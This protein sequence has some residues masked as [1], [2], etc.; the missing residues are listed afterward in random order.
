VG[1]ELVQSDAGRAFI[2][3]VDAIPQLMAALKDTT[4]RYAYVSEGFA[5]RV[6]RPPHR[7]VG[8]TVHELFAHDLAASYAEQD[9]SVLRTGRPLRSHLELIVRADRSLGWYVT[10]KTTITHDGHPIGLAVLSVDLH[11]QLH[12]AHA[13]LAD[14]IA[15]IRAEV[16]RAWRVADLADVAGL[17]PVQ[18]E[19]QS[20]RTLGLSPRK[21]IQRLRI[22]HA[23][24]LIT[25]TPATIG[26]ISA[27]C[28]FYD[29]SSFTRQFRAVLGLTPG[30]YRI[31]G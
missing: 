26:E 6:G 3:L 13:G 27:I 20:R 23:V 5:H 19:R 22:E 21:L 1:V 31:S 7:I 16:G 30:A 8:R 11:S 2:D 29:Q 9:E 24:H 15:A 12:S 18:L 25:T 10:S 28:G 4:G 14:A 17:S